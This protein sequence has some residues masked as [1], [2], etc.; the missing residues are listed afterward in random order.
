MI[1]F[2]NLKED[3]LKPLLWDLSKQYEIQMKD[4]IKCMTDIV[5]P[6]HSNKTPAEAAK[7]KSEMT[8][9][10][11]VSDY[12]ID[13][14]KD[15]MN[16]VLQKWEGNPLC[17]MQFIINLMCNGMITTKDKV[18]YPNGKKFFDCYQ[19]NDWAPLSV[20]DIM[21]SINGYLLDQYL[22]EGRKTTAAFN[23]DKVKGIIILKSVSVIGEEFTLR[24][25]EFINPL[26][27][28]DIDTIKDIL[29]DLQL[30]EFIEI[31]DD[32]DAKNWRCRFSKKFMRE[33]L[34][35]RLLFR[36]QKKTL[37]QLSADFIQNHPNLEPNH[38]L[39]QK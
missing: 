17:S 12:F 19:L 35:Q 37:H 14:Q 1:D 2:S 26:V 5:D 9:S 27:N 30:K 33:T 7:M 39:E 6:E 16:V 3:E 18:L 29:L 36:Q 21:S 23:P 13:I 22:K 8:K 10:F 11:N 15:V 32:S 31:L 28:E 34:Y 38:E 4:E 20:P 25:I 24:Q